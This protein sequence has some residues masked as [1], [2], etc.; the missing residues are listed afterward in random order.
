MAPS[1]KHSVDLVSQQM[2]GSLQSGERAR[3]PRKLHG[4]TVKAWIA[5]P[6][7]EGL[8]DEQEVFPYKKLTEEKWE[9][10]NER[11]KADSQQETQRWQAGKTE[12]RQK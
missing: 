11:K 3:G 1:P 9:M 6:T 5:P 2:L 4:A 7:E 12:Q 10:G 8:R